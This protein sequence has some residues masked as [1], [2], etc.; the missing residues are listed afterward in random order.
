MGGAGGAGGTGNGGVG[1]GAVGG[2]GGAGGANT[3]NAGTFNMSNAMASVGQTAAGIMVAN[4]NSGMA[5]LV[6]Q[7]VTVQANL[8]VGR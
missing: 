5:S 6:Q 1:N 8:S 7:A 4:Q 3:V 2:A